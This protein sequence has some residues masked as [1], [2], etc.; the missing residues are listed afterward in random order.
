VPEY[1]IVDGDAAALEIW[2]PD[3]ERP[4][5]VDDR[6]VWRPDGASQPFELDVRSLFE[7]VADKAPLP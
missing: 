5:L 1:W 7:S 2:H 3:D 6:V 4:A